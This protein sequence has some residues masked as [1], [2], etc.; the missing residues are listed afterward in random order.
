ME[1]WKYIDWIDGIEKEKYRVYPSGKITRRLK[2]AAEKW[3]EHKPKLDRSG[4]LHVILT[5]PETNFNTNLTLGR[6]VLC[7]F[8]RTK[9]TTNE[10]IYKDGNVKNC[11]IDNLEW[12][13]Y[14]GEYED[15][16]WKYIDW[17]DEIPKTK[18][19]VSNYGR[20]VN[21]TNM[22]LLKIVKNNNS[23][24]VVLNDLRNGVCKPFSLLRLVGFAFV[25]IKGYDKEWLDIIRRSEDVEPEKL[26]H[27]DNLV[28]V[29]PQSTEPLSDFTPDPDLPEEWKY[30]DWLDE[31]DPTMYKVSNY[32]RVINVQT[33]RLVTVYCDTYSD[34]KGYLEVQLWKDMKAKKVFHASLCRLVA[35]AFLPKP[36]FELRYLVAQYKDGNIYNLRYDNLYW[37]VAGTQIREGGMTPEEAVDI[38]NFIN[39]HIYDFNSMV[40]FQEFV[41]EQCVGLGKHRAIRYLRECG[42]YGQPEKM[43]DFRNKAIRKHRTDDELKEIWECLIKN[44]GKIVKTIRD[45]EGKFTRSQIQHAKSKYEKEHGPIGNGGAKCVKLVNL[46]D[47]TSQTFDS[48]KA[49]AESLGMCIGYLSKRIIQGLPFK[50]EQYMGYYIDDTVCK[51]YD[52]PI[53]VH[54]V[55]G[56]FIGEYDSLYTAADALHLDSV[57]I[58]QYLD[59]KRGDKRGFVFKRK[60]QN[61]E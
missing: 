24:A 29:S 10:I 9:F 49:A 39:A 6:I 46:N 52:F 51:S 60:T 55:D 45:L 15:E 21:M 37:V 17:I 38:I 26:N 1:E 20:V 22:R 41:N 44:K 57:H 8:K 61:E 40:E 58:Q 59:V 50:N 47:G 23:R 53:I 43:T 35:I 56:N 42:I 5:N 33:N 19:K 31:V 11:S 3:V 34:P 32:G 7:T 28:W 18:Y 27:S 2:S 14:T 36:I 4:H 12:D 16:E 48:L 13:A 25:D 30:I 54:D